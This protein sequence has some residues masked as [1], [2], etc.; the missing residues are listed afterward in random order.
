MGAR[1]SWRTQALGGPLTLTVG[2]DAD[3]MKEHRQGFVN[4]NGVLG[5]QNPDARSHLSVI[6]NSINASIQ[7]IQTF[8]QAAPAPTP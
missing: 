1:V 5:I 4:N 8:V 3:R 2:A 6:I 7:I